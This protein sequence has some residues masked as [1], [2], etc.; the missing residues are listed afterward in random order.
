MNPLYASMP[1]TI[2]EKMSGLARETGSIN[3]GQGFPDSNGPADVVAAAAAALTDA[4]NQ[5]PP[6]A[7]LAVLRQAVAG[8]YRHHQQIALDADREVIIT[9]GA[10]EALAASILALVSPGDTVLLFQPLYD[11]YLPLVLRA[12]GIPRFVRLEPPHWR[13][14][15]EALD[16]AFTPDVRLAILNNPLNPTASMFSA[17][18]LALLA[19]RVVRNDAVVICD[20]VW[21]HVVFDG[22][23]H[24]PLMAL[25]G[26]RDRTVKIGSGGKIFSLTGWK[27]GWMCAAP[28]L[29]EPL[30]RAHQ[31]LT[32]TTAP[33]LQAAVAHGLGKD[34]GYFTA[35][36]ADFARSRDRLV[37]GLG[38]AGYVTLPSA[39]TYFVPIDLAASGIMLDDA[40]FCDRLVRDHG[41]AAIPVSAF[42]AENPVTSVVR[43]CFA[44]RD[45]TLDPAI[46]RL[47]DARRAMAR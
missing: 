47:A 37:Q 32:F 43:L 17:E 45:E 40:G 41:V 9:S 22:R 35:M 8:H 5:Y 14:T 18:E 36:R 46:G 11:A 28:R 1:T 6:M 10:T 4:S 3:L 44:K 15:A 12:G 27:V 39:G 33:N 19:D 23:R 38:E 34:D 29:A 2:F 24:V 31:F 30:S 25:P 21:E 13:L 16:A 42:Y 7:G 26:M 20:E